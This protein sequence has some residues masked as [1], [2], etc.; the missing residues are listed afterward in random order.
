MDLVKCQILGGGGEEHRAELEKKNAC[1]NSAVA[2]EITVNHKENDDRVLWR[3]KGANS[4]SRRDT[5]Q[6][7]TGL[8]DRSRSEVSGGKGVLK[9][10]KK[11]SL[12]DVGPSPR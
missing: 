10:K 12:G 5:G 3:D 4:R 6:T 2:D 1:Q 7:D 9:E 8:G 11:R